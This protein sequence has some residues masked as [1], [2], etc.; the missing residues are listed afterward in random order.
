MKK[1]IPLLLL[2]STACTTVGPNYRAPSAAQLSVPGSYGSG[3]Q[4][5]AV[6]PATY[7]QDLATWWTQFN[8]PLIDELVG[9]ALGANLDLET[10]RARLRQARESVRQAEAGRVPSVGASGSL[11]ESANS[12]GDGSTNISIGADASWEADLFGGVSRSIEA[13]SSDAEASA[14]DLAAVQVSLVGEIATNYVQLRLAQQREKLAR[15]NLEMAEENL[16]IAQWRLQAGLVSSIDVEQARG[17]RAQIAASIPT[18]EQ[19]FANAAHRLGVLTGQAPAAMIERLKQD[20][21]IPHGPETIAAGIP[22]DTLRQRPDVRS[23]E[24]NLAAQTARIGVAEADLYPSLSIGGNIG[25]AALSLGGLA[26]LITGSLF[27]TVSQTIFDGGRNR[28]EVRSQEAAADAAFATYKQS[29]LTAIEDVENGLVA[30]QTAQQ[31]EANFEEAADSARNQ[32]ILA[33]SQYRAGL[34]DFQQLLEAERSL[35]SAND[36]L[37]I[38]QADQTLAV[39]QLFRALGGGW[40]PSAES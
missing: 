40:S 7:A 26:S 17:L 5:G 20:G 8:D 29:V 12:D 31:R 23:A 4:P 9:R 22:A 24:R 21:A 36:S 14:Y 15:A 2:A 19:N 34:S 10:A 35:N 16:Q 1:L 28:S 39:I 13:A 6:A 25:T 11:S 38:N 33:R 30:R 37:L 27:T 18:L 3:Q 32:A